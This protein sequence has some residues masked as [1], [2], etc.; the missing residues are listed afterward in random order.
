MERISASNIRYIGDFINGYPNGQGIMQFPNGDI[1]EGDVRYFITMYG[2][3]LIVAAIL[4]FKRP[5]ENVHR[6]CFDIPM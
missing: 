2:N 6:N 5:S 1:Y 4:F 3:F